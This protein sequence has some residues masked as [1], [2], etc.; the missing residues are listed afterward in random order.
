MEQT[1]KFF[2]GMLNALFFPDL[3]PDRPVAIGQWIKT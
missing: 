2:L 1:V 3:G